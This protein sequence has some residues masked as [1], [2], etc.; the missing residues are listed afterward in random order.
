[1]PGGY[2]FH[3]LC[4][5]FKCFPTTKTIMTMIRLCFNTENPAH[6]GVSAELSLATL[7]DGMILDFFLVGMNMKRLMKSDEMIWPDKILMNR[8]QKE[9]NGT[10]FGV[11]IHPGWQLYTALKSRGSGSRFKEMHSPKSHFKKHAADL[12]LPLTD[13][14]L[15]TLVLHNFGRNMFHWQLLRQD[16]EFSCP[17][18]CLPSGFFRGVLRVSN[19]R[20]AL[21]CLIQL[22]AQLFSMI[23]IDSDAPNLSHHQELLQSV[24]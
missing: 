5:F 10:T 22:N 13:C 17:V 12:M 23:W 1:M 24:T 7:G 18:R 6:L 4:L 3:F 20:T 11:H 19:S 21:N 15:V 9:R 16:S 8:F 2:L 14:R